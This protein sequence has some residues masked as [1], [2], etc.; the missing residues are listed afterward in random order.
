MTGINTFGAGTV[1][2]FGFQL[3]AAN[4]FTGGAA[5]CPQ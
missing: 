1:D 3:V 5:A 4:V 2:G